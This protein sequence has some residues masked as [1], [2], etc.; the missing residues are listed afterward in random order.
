M[1]EPQGNTT[2]NTYLTNE[3]GC[4]AGSPCNSACSSDPACL[5]ATMNPGQTCANCLAGIVATDTCMTAWQ[6][7]CLADAACKQFL[8]DVDENCSFLP[9]LDGGG[10]DA[11]ADG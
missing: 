3:C 7:A 8:A 1:L 6:N 4:K 9:T 5:S 11:P 10:A 2:L